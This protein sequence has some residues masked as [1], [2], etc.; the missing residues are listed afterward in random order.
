MA[1]HGMVPCIYFPP[2][3]RSNTSA[4]IIR[5]MKMQNVTE[6]FGSEPTSILFLQHNFISF[7][8]GE[9]KSE[10]NVNRLPSPPPGIQHGSCSQNGALA[11]QFSDCCR[12]PRVD[13]SKS[14]VGSIAVSRCN[15]R[16]CDFLARNIARSRCRSVSVL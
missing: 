5:P 1:W 10:D 4:S 7:V 14:S 13:R 16:L 2:H 8:T 3:S 12:W 6:F 9:T 11:P 15:G